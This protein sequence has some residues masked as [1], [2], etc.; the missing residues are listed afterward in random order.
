MIYGFSLKEYLCVKVPLQGD[1]GVQTRVFFSKQKFKETLVYT[2]LSTWT[3][4]S[5][6]LWDEKTESYR[7]VSAGFEIA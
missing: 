5:I 6:N 4:L 2:I 7:L 1:L 3:E